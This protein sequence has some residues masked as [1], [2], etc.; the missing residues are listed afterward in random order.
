MKKLSAVIITYNEE[1]N[2]ERCLNSLVNVVDDIVVVDSFS[3]DQTEKICLSKGVRFIQHAFDGHIEQ[4][5]WAI[6]Q[7]KYPHILSLDADEALS[8]KMG[9]EIIRI[10]ENW[11]SDGYIFN[12][13]TNYCDKW[14]KN[15]G[16]YPDKKLRLWDSSK[17]S[18]QGI[19]PHD[20]FIMEKG[21]TTQHIKAD[22]LHYSYYSISDHLKQVNYFTDIASRA[23][24]EKGKRSSLIKILVSPILKFISSYF[25]KTGFL[26]GYYGF[27]I[28]V[29]SSFATFIKYIKLK[30]IQ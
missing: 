30:Q 10:K 2:I 26:D 19:N 1:R 24:F 21:A 13:L 22:I 25:F 17:G 15:G 11:E 3:T 6:T 14:I 27:V 5:N 8:E 20:E 12:R 18:W 9:K 4:K 28:S 23:Y 7:A 29:I 16:W